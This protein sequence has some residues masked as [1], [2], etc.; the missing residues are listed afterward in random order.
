M[1]CF[2]FPRR[3]P[4]TREVNGESPL[5]GFR[6]PKCGTIGLGTLNCPQPER[7]SRSQALLRWAQKAG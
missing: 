6:G 7:F 2:P 1:V 3:V 4:I 5:G